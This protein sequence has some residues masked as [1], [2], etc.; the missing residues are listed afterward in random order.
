M[1]KYKIIDYKKTELV[2]HHQYL[3]I[4]IKQN[5]NIIYCY[6]MFLFLK[7]NGTHFLQ[8]GSLIIYRSKKFTKNIK[9]GHLYFLLK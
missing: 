2:T 6:R 8:N 7:C 4:R 9:T 1:K 5:R 3:I